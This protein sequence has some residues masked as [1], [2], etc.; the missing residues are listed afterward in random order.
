[1]KIEKVNCWL[2]DVDGVSYRRWHATDW[3]RLHEWSG[4]VYLLLD[5]AQKM[6]Q[7]FQEEVKRERTT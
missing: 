5:N 7:Q 4:W 3:E 1:M 6:E 2:I